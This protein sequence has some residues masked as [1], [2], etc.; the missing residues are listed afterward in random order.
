MEFSEDAHNNYFFSQPHQPF[1]LLALVNAITTMVIFVL[2]YKSVIFMDISASNFHAYALTYL[3]FTP[4][5]FGF[6]FTTF[7]KFSSTHPL[8][9]KVY[10][11]VFTLFYIGSALF[12]LGSVVS[13]VLTA[14]GMVITF[15]GHVLGV[16][17]LKNIYTASTMTDKHDI[18]WITLSMIFG[19]LAHFIFILSQLFF[20]LMV[21]FSTEI[22]T[23]LYLFLLTF[24]VAQRMVPFFSHTLAEKNED[25]LKHVALLLG[26]HILLE[27]IYTNSSFIIDLFI[28]Y[29]IGKE[30]LRWQLPFPNPNPLLWI[31]HVAIYW[32]P[33]AFA[34]SGLS[35][36]I[37]LVWDVSFLALDIHTILLGFVF[38]IL[39]GFGTRVTL[40]HSDNQMHA[41]KFTVYLFYW[42]QV[43]VGVRILTSFV[44][45]FGWD[46]MILFD[47]SAAV[48]IMMFIA[49]AVHYAN[50]LISGKKIG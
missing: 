35:N 10:L 33:I 38:T 8:K 19:I 41:D 23:Y 48:W 29:I 31:L 17:I 24:S 32:I 28:A 39:I 45:A 22:S 42:T 50:V 26:L 37:G 7:P 14:L 40:G 47:I 30:L 46:F 6:L 4:A 2:S 18:F 43:V 12:L 13:P 44:T 20:P 9:K 34:L 5:F 1:F 3:F 49:W 27:G 21:G 36:L 15:F 25:L 11:R 16:L